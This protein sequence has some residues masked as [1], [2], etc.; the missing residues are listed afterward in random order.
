MTGF[1][2]HK[3]EDSIG[4]LRFSNTK[5]QRK[6]KKMK[7]RKKFKI[8]L[9]FGDQQVYCFLVKF[10]AHL[11]SISKRCSQMPFAHY[12]ASVVIHVD[13]PIDLYI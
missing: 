7:W 5:I 4:L 12:T 6:Q 1:L 2:T 11:K 3:V 9:I 10:R 13:T 8:E